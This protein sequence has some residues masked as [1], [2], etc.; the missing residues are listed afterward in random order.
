MKYKKIK[1]ENNKIISVDESADVNVPMVI[2][3]DDIE[4][5]LFKLCYYDLRNPDN[6]INKSELT[7]EELTIPQVHGED[8]ANV[9]CSCDNCFYGRT[10]MAEYIINKAAQQKVFY[11]VWLI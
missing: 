7:T 1:L 8:F 5:F 9:L 6:C 4:K 2:V 11:S 10:E 3:E